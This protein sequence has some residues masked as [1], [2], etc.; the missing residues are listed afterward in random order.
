MTVLPSIPPSSDMAHLLLSATNSAG[1]PEVLLLA[2]LNTSDLLIF[3]ATPRFCLGRQDLLVQLYPGQFQ[4]VFRATPI[5]HLASSALS[6]WMV[7]AHLQNLQQWHAIH[8]SVPTR[9]DSILVGG[10]TP[11]IIAMNRERVSTYDHFRGICSKVRFILSHLSK[12]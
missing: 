5:C 10:R 2:M 9:T 1:L 4:P 12:V 6:T 8:L 3:A 11:M 7:E